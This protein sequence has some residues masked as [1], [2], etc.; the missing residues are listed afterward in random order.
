MRRSLP[1][2]ARQRIGT[3]SP[4]KR[5]SGGAPP[6]VLQVLT[7]DTIGG[8]ELMTATLVERLDRRRVDCRLVTLAPPGP[9]ARRMERSGSE[10]RSLGN[11]GL[12][13]AFVRLAR[14]LVSERYDVVN[15]YGIK[16][17]TVTRLLVRV[18]SP[19]TRFVCG[20]R[21]QSPSETAR[22]RGPKLRLALLLE[23]AGSPLV[24]IYDAN[25]RAALEVLAS[26]GIERAKFRFIPN[27]I[28]ASA[29]PPRQ[30][31]RPRPPVILC[32]ARFVPRKRHLDVV[33]AAAQ[34]AERGVEFR[35]VLAGYGP[36]HAEVGR[37]VRA[38]RLDGTVTLPGQVEGEAL[39]ELYSQAELFC[40]ASVS[41][42]MSGSVMEAMASGVPVVGGDVSGVRELVEHGRTGLL[43]K[44]RSPAALADA[45]AA[46][47]DDPDRAERFG[48]A[49]REKVV[50]EFGLER[51]VAEKERLYRALVG[52]G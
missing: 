24:D 13:V 20:V 46:M 41:E 8:T 36:T 21:E 38:R 15:A 11:R 43:V 7:C 27:G 4:R 44:P 17:T 31:G 45:M 48:A 6:A 42:G 16:S 52:Q 25:S 26:V 50:G 35:M 37:A 39:R 10:M 3:R 12:F 14:I 19:G 34:L 40:T 49:G 32:V 1:F 47:L 22:S 18:L 28:D 30:A 9:I 5:H 33:A 23:R 2:V 51:M 29:W